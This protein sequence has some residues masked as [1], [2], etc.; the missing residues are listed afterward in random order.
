MTFGV[1]RNEHG[2]AEFAIQ[3]VRDTKNMTWTP[4]KRFV[5]NHSTD[6]THHRLLTDS[7]NRPEHSV[8]EGL[9]PRPLFYNPVLTMLARAIADQAFRDYSTME[10]LLAIEPPEDEIYHLR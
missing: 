2:K 10:E 1:F 7:M 9:E 5:S 8:H 4:E 6:T 3:V